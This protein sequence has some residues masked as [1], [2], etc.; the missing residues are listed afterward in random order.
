VQP[1]VVLYLLWVLWLLSWLAVAIIGDSRPHR[2]GGLM[3]AFYRLTIIAASLLLFAI[4]PWPGLDVQ[5]RIWERAPSEETGWILSAVAFAGFVL[6]WWAMVERLVATKRHDSVIARG[7]YG[8]IRQPAHLGLMIA[9][10]ATAGMFGR[11]SSLAGAGIL[12]IAFLVRIIV[13]ERALRDEDPAYHDYAER[14][15]MFLPIPKRRQPPFAQVS[16]L[17]SHAATAA[18]RPSPAAVDVQSSAQRSEPEPT[19]PPVKTEAPRTGEKPVAP[20]EG[21]A[22]PAVASVQLSLT[23]DQP[24]EED[25]AALSESPSK[26]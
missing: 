7:P 23:L 18:A 5:Y 20:V 14:V 6:V 21:G 24:S 19:A 15:P 25:V 2:L 1:I 3:L 13:D 22:R 17:T 10:L 9:V 11:P 8:V 4:T 12:A 16:T 26:P